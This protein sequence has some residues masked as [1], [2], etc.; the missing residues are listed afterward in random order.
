MRIR[1]QRPHYRI[2]VSEDA[3]IADF[4]VDEERL[5]IDHNYLHIF[6][7]N[8]IFDIKVVGHPFVYLLQAVKQGNNFEVDAYCKM[9]WRVTQNIYTDYGFASDIIHAINALDERIDA[10]AKEKAAAVTD[11]EET[12]SQAIMEDVAAYADA[13]SEDEREQILQE[14]REALREVLSEQG[15][16]VTKEIVENET[17]NKD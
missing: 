13:N 7:P 4:Y 16:V 2:K 3:F 11:Q 5:D 9:L 1:K 6:T 12:A 17:D 8:G 14:G 15:E 10:K